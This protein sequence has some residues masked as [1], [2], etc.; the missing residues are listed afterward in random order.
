M[1]ALGWR[2]C[3]ILAAMM[4]VAA[5][6]AQVDVDEN[7]DASEEYGIEAMPTFKFIKVCA[8]HCVH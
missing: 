2:H 6:A 3:C 7:S 1:A 8:I 4:V 5:A